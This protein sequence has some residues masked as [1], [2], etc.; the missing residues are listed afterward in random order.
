MKENE[1]NIKELDMKE[2]LFLFLNIKGKISEKSK[3]SCNSGRDVPKIFVA[4]TVVKR[5]KKEPSYKHKVFDDDE[6]KKIITALNSYYD[7]PEKFYPYG[8]SSIRIKFENNR[9][10]TIS[11]L[12][13]ELYDEIIVKLLGL[14]SEDFSN[15]F[16]IASFAYRGSL[17]FKFNYYSVDMHPSRVSTK[18]DVNNLLRLTVYIDFNDKLNINFR[19]LQKQGKTKA[20][21]FRINLSYFSERFLGELKKVN[22]Y[23]YEEFILNKNSL[24]SKN[25][26]TLKGN[27]D[28][29]RRIKFYLDNI[30]ERKDLNDSDITVL[31]KKLEFSNE[32][33]KKEK[34]KRSNAARSFAKLAKNDQCAA[35]HKKYSNEDRSFKTR[36]GIWYFELHHVIS[37][38]NRDIQTEDPDNY[39]KLCSTCHRALTPNRAEEEYQKEIIK[40]ILDDDTGVVEYVERVKRKKNSKKKNVDFVYNHLK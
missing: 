15:Y 10:I 22:P 31:R 34:K 39:V 7:F 17:D 27:A 30:V 19:E 23:R 16:A 2:L 20:T 32:N 18:Q 9:K 21:Q 1:L 25:D 36:D 6:R 28:F 14:T 29:L 13:Q 11:K 3:S 33:N 8:T 5:S 40:N 37:F 38:A 12:L 35:C 26:K 4:E 24:K